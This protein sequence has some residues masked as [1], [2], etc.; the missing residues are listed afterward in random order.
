MKLKD[1][2]KQITFYTH[3]KNTWAAGNL[4]SIEVQLLGSLLL[5]IVLEQFILVTFLLFEFNHEFT[6]RFGA[7][8]LND[9]VVVAVGAV[10]VG[11]LEFTNVL[12]EA[13]LAFLADHGKLH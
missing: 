6:L 13:L 12:A 7:L 9:E 10:L 4:Y 8:G 11:L 1:V 5:S 3:Q 2:L